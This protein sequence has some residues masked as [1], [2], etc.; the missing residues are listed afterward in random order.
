FE[1][2]IGENIYASLRTPDNSLGVT[3]ARYAELEAHNGA[4]VNMD[5]LSTWSET[6]SY[7]FDNN[8]AGIVK[9][10]QP[11]DF[12]ELVIK[13]PDNIPAEGKVS[14]VWTVSGSEGNRADDIMIA[15]VKLINPDPVPG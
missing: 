11:G 8:P 1:V 5:Q 4:Q 15:D 12:A 7:S 13:L 9:D 10:I 6:Y 2:R 14:L 3:E